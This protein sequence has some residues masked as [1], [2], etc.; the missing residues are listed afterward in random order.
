[1]WLLKTVSYLLGSCLLKLFRNFVSNNHPWLYI[2]LRS[3]GCFVAWSVPTG[4]EHFWKIQKMRDFLSQNWPNRVSST[5]N[6]LDCQRH[7]WKKK[8]YK[9]STVQNRAGSRPKIPNRVYFLKASEIQN[10]AKFCP[11]KVTENDSVKV[12]VEFAVFDQTVKF[13]KFY[14]RLCIHGPTLW[15]FTRI[16]YFWT[17]LQKKI[18]QSLDCANLGFQKS[19]GNV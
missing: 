13:R 6:P 1:M 4:S 8:R 11:I 10:L 19:W 15:W 2:S 18:K 14:I 12:L 9:I 17:H 5:F 7:V 3:R 16:G